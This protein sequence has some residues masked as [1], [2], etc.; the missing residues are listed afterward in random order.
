MMRAPERYKL[1]SCIVLENRIK[2]VENDAKGNNV[3]MNEIP[4]KKGKKYGKM[5]IILR[6][7][8]GLDIG[9]WLAIR[10]RGGGIG[11]WI[12]TLYFCF[13]CKKKAKKNG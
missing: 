1:G 11:F 6:Q 5:K 7:K 4:E 12:L 9:V 10:T 13:I 3:L 8:S 2:Y